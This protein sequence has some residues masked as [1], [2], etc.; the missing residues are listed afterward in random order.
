[1]ISCHI[2]RLCLVVMSNTPVSLADV[3]NAHLAIEPHVCKTPVCP[4]IF[5]ALKA[6]LRSLRFTRSVQCACS[7]AMGGPSQCSKS[8]HAVVRLLCFQ[9]LNCAEIDAHAH[10]SILLKAECLQ[11]TGSFKIRGATYAVQS[12][13]K[14]KEGPASATGVYTHRSAC[15]ALMVSSRVATSSPADIH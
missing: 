5:I 12:S 10:R 3:K 13:L 4:C 14:S 8:S 7:G 2:R 6:M 15:K 1:M 11:V 9:V